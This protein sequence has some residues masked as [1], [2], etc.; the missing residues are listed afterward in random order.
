MPGAALLLVAAAALVAH[1][2]ADAATTM[3]S[4]TVPA[5]GHCGKVE[6]TANTTGIASGTKVFWF[7]S[8]EKNRFLELLFL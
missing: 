4:Q 6:V 3:A 2:H 8:S 5:L 7:F 1:S